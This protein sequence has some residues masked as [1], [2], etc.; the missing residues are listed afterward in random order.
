MAFVTPIFAKTLF[1]TGCAKLPNVN[2]RPEIRTTGRFA[3]RAKIVR[4]SIEEEVGTALKDAMRAKDSEKLKALR[5]IR[6]AFLTALKAEGAGDKLSD[7]DAVASLRKLA[8]MRQESIDMFQKAN[9]DDL[10]QAET[11]ELNIINQWLPTL[12]SQDQMRTWAEQAIEKTAASK[13]GDMG[14]VMG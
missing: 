12:A 7:K 3:R 11:Y 4:A 8:K 9:R 13:P 6:A 2:V 5:A 1:I 14:K 10:V